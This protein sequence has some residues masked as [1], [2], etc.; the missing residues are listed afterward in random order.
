MR[1]M[2]KPRFLLVYPLTIWLFWVAS[3]TEQS[4]RLGLLFVLLGEA[5]RLWANGYVGHVKV[6]W[7][8][9][10][11][12][13]PRIG[14]LITAGPYAYV[15]HPLYLGTF[16]IGVGFCII[17]GN[18]WLALAALGFF[19]VIYRRK[20]AQEEAILLEE[21]GPE[22]ERYQQA[23]PRWLPT[24]RHNPHPHGRWSW[25]GIMASKELKTLVWVLVLLNVMYFRGEL[26]TAHEPFLQRHGLKHVLLLALTIVLNL[27]DVTYELLHRWRR[28]QPPR[29]PAAQ[30]A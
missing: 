24:G 17:V 26:I 23:V 10:W 29:A 14:Q 21:W 30:G 1:L 7:T 12:H 6:N 20:M 8:Q 5:L 25:Q 11:R 9:K 4:L 3:P 13:D 22:F 18:L 15:R 19:L 27:S 2:R 28:R 16:L